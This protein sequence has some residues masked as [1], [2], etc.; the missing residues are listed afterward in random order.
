MSPRNLGAVIFSQDCGSRKWLSRLRTATGQFPAHELC[1][2]RNLTCVLSSAREPGNRRLANTHLWARRRFPGSLSGQ[3]FF[4]NGRSFGL[5]GALDKDLTIRKR[6][7]S[8]LTF[9]PHSG[10]LCWRSCNSCASLEA[11][12]MRKESFPGC[13]TG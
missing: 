2:G 8:S 12:N 1:K 6:N 3:H 7:S 9:F 5:S 11:Q 10:P 13:I 4:S